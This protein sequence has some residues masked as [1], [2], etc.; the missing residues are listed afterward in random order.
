MLTEC[1]IH[2]KKEP[3]NHTISVS[4]EGKHPLPKRRFFP[5]PYNGRGRSW[6]NPCMKVYVAVL[7]N[8]GGLLATQNLH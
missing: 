5:T 7:Y 1:V 6:S 4:A 8:S 2:I 3:L